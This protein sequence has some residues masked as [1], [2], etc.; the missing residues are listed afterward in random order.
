MCIHRRSQVLMTLV[1][2]VFDKS[3]G[4]PAVER[5]LAHIYSVHLF[6]GISA[7][8]EGSRHKR[9]VAFISAIAN[10]EQV[11]RTFHAAS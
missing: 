4:A 7:R 3:R 8:T 9:N 1:K 5:V 10:L 6:R 11:L 2:R